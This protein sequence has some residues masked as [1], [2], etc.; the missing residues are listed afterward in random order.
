[1]KLAEKSNLL[2]KDISIFCSLLAFQVILAVTKYYLTIESSDT[3]AV[4]NLGLTVVLMLDH[5]AL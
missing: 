2:I 3:K 4:A 1:M 5:I